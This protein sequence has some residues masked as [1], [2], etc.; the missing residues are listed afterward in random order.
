MEATTFDRS[1]Y[2]RCGQE[3]RIVQD[4]QDNGQV[5]RFCGVCGKAPMGRIMADYYRG[6]AM[7]AQA[8]PDKEIA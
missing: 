6:L 8:M 5:D 1:Y 4:R 3:A 7:L 2:C